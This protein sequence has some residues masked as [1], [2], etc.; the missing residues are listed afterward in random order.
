MLV[1]TI[2]IDNSIASPLSPED[3][4]KY[5]YLTEMCEKE[6]TDIKVIQTH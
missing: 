6:M 5:Y 4:V 1:V 2:V 3:F